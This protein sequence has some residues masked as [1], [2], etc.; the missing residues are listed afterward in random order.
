MT[1]MNELI[2]IVEEAVEGG[3]TARA[4]GASIFTD[5]DTLPN[6]MPTFGTPSSVISRK[7]RLRRSCDFIS[8]ERN[9]SPYEDS[10]DPVGPDLVQALAVS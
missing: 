1:K 7:G 8:S 3:F 4:L 6:C 9:Y 5:A 10:R 2:F